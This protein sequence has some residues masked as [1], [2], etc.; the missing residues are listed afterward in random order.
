MRLS[1]WASY[2]QKGES[3]KVPPCHSGVSLLGIQQG[4]DLS[5]LL[6]SDH[7]P[8]RL[9]DSSVSNVLA[10]QLA[11]AA[12]E[13]CTWG[14]TDVQAGLTVEKVWTWMLSTATIAEW[15]QVTPTLPLW[16]TYPPTEPFVTGHIRSEFKV[17]AFSWY[18]ICSFPPFPLF[19][20][21]PSI[22][23]PLSPSYP[24]PC[25]GFPDLQT[26]MVVNRFPCTSSLAASRQ[27]WANPLMSPGGT[28]A[29]GKHSLLLETSFPG[30]QNPSSK[31]VNVLVI[32]SG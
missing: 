25:C 26:F 14:G 27:W 9:T 16:G 13:P 31:P 17:L 22:P 11:C 4:R 29:S 21:P 32:N 19:P 28:E 6:L 20:P 10:P 15:W 18:R 12:A 23:F 7:S 2:V 30:K 3:P 5:F 24:F 1:L 8:Q